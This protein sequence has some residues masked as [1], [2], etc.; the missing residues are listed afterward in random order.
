MHACGLAV[1]KLLCVVVDDFESSFAEAD[2]CFQ[3]QPEKNEDQNI[4]LIF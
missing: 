3:K 4:G 2:H 1:D